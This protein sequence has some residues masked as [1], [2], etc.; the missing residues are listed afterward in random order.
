M[1]YPLSSPRAEGTIDQH[2]S[3]QDVQS[4]S[5]AFYFINFFLYIYIGTFSTFYT[6]NILIQYVWIHACTYTYF[7]NRRTRNFTLDSIY[8]NVFGLPFI[9]APEWQTWPPRTSHTLFMRLLFNQYFTTLILYTVYI[10]IYIL[11]LPDSWYISWPRDYIMFWL[12]L[13]TYL[14]NYIGIQSPQLDHI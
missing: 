1:H 10:Y 2:S 7:A 4:A 9:F 3:L 5:L 11:L 13:F 12:H 14:F 8:V 6:Y